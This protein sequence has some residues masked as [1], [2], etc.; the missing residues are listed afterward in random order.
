MNETL[1]N[2]VTLHHA[3]FAVLVVALAT[4]LGALAFQH[5][6][7]YAPCALCLQQRYA[8]YIGIP[9]AALAFVL[10]W[11]GKTNIAMIL[12]GLYG[13]GFLINAG[14][15]VYHSGVEWKWWPGPE[16][17]GGGDFSA[18][19]GNLLESLKTAKPV[20]CNEAPWR[21]LGLSFAGWNVMISAGL[22]VLAFLGIR[23][24]RSAT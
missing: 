9:L 3:A 20:S 11:S 23:N 8:Y 24:A 13:L 2:R 4:I 5:I 17:C 22:A 12:L 19:G 10:A 14:I 1:L 7:G 16:A 18:V 21:F 15:G 6:G